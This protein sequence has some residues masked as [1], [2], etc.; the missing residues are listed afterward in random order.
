MNSFLPE[1][2]ANA[3]LKKSRN[4]IRNILILISDWQKSRKICFLSIQKEQRH[5]Y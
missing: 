2:R 5:N 4:N 1:G 3:L